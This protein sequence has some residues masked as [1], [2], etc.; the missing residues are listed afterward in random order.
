MNLED[1]RDIKPPVGFPANSFF[2]IIA[3]VI[4]ALAALIFLIKFF[5]KRLAK[6][7][8]QILNPPKPAHQ[9]A[10]EALEA[11]RR[12]NLPGAGKIKEYY[13]R[14]SDIIRRYIEERFEIRAPEMTTEEFLSN[15]RSS[16][17]LSGT[18]KN[19]LKEF[20]N[21][22]DIVKFAKYGPVQKEIDQSFAAA[23]KLVKE[24]EKAPENV[25]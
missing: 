25:L 14:L 17:I 8:E 23:L 13:F 20:L 24:T 1:I 12:Q 4:I 19:L 5:K 22:C 21:L 3:A 18:H 7:K 10:L 16:G 15:L 11:L 9:R 6:K 2:F